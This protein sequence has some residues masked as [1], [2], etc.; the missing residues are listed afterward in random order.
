MSQM[1]QSQRHQLV[2]QMVW[3]QR[4]LLP[5]L[6]RGEGGGERG[7]GGQEGGREGGRVW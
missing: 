5:L 3:S 6:V 1:V 7:G 2:E 4:D